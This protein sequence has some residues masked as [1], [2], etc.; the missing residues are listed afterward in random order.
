MMDFIE[1]TFKHAP[2]TLPPDVGD[3]HFEVVVR[4]TVTK[5]KIGKNLD[6]NAA[7]ILTTG[8]MKAQQDMMRTQSKIRG[9]TMRSA[10]VLSLLFGILA[11]PLMSLETRS[12]S[13]LS[14]AVCL[15]LLL[16]FP[17]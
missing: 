4:G 6:P 14:L 2:R 13:A 1:A 7:S 17:T 10:A 16:I 9:A 3:K 12:A 11:L 5:V 8:I 15:L